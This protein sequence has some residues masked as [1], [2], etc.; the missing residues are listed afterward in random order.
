MQ[1]KPEWDIILTHEAVPQAKK[2][3]R[4]MSCGKFTKVYDPQTADKRKAKYV[5]AAQMRQKGHLK[6]EDGPIE[7]EMYF[8]L[9]QPKIDAQRSI[10]RGIDPETLFHCKKPDVDNFAKWYADILNGLAYHDDSQIS[11]LHCE[12]RYSSRP[13]AE[14]FLRKGGVL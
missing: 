3:P 6:L 1:D 10:K 12:K 8:Y 2:R 5:L 4:F 11:I 14:I 7:A 13:R 9:P